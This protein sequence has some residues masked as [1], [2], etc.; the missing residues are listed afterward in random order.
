MAALAKYMTSKTASEKPDQEMGLKK[1]VKSLKVKKSPGE[2]DDGNSAAKS[3]EEMEKSAQSDA[4]MKT[5]LKKI[6]FGSKSK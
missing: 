6:G 2:G 5:L 4:E 3:Y 1:L